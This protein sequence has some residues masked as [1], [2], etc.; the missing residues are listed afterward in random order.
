MTVAMC[1][2]VQPCSASSAERVW[3]VHTD[4]E[5]DSRNKLGNL[6][7]WAK[8]FKLKLVKVYFNAALL[9]KL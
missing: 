9:R 8:N 6:R 1:V 7:E 3:Y 5:S 2:L 4:S